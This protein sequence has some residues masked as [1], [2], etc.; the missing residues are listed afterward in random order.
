MHRSLLLGAVSALALSSPAFAADM[1]RGEVSYK[2]APMHVAPH[3]WTGFYVGVH[4]G[5][6]DGEWA[7]VL[8]LDPAPTSLANLGYANPNQSVDG[9]G[10]FGGA[11]VGYNWQRGAWV[12]GLEADI[13][14]ADIEGS[15][16][17]T[18]RNFGSPSSPLFFAKQH[19]FEIDWF[20]T[21]RARLG[22]STGSV[23]AYVTGGFAWAKVDANLSVIA[24]DGAVTYT[25]LGGAS[26]S[27]THTGY[28]IGGGVEALLGKGW[29]LK[30]E[31][32]YVDLG[33]EDYAFPGQKVNSSGNPVT[34]KPVDLFNS[35]DLDFHTVRVGLNYKLQR[36]E[37][38]LK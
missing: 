23:L 24:T 7:G 33:S 1:Y 16:T 6:A 25:E 27:A 37:A 14:F 35:V 38:P 12:A 3:I 11:Q 32:L 29:S 13:S 36:D 22:Y 20:G 26:D 9:D 10:F 18:T 17:F 2:D 19:S 30:A 15:E 28:T 34:G 31:Y 8:S 21:A 5:Y 4:G